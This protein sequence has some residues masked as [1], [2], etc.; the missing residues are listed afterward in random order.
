[1]RKFLVFC[2]LTIAGFDVVSQQAAKNDVLLKLNGEE[3][4]GKV[5]KINENNV[6]FSYAGETLTYMIKKDDIMKITF[7]SGRI[8]IFNKP[9]LPS[10]SKNQPV[11]DNKMTGQPASLE[12]HH[13]KVAILPFS[14]IK[15][16]QTTADAMTEKVQ[17]EGYELLNKHAGVYTILNPRTTNALLLKAGINN[18]NIKGYT[19]DDLCNIL[20]VEYVIDCMVSVDKTTQTVVQSNSGQI[21][22]KNEK[23]KKFNTYTYGTA[24]QNYK[25][26]LTLSIYNDKG[27]TVYSKDRNSFWN[28]EDAYKNTLEYLLKHSPLY[29]K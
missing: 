14:F 17:T 23:D 9:A 16:G 4:A 5:L 1:M 11:S 27:N 29:T 15:D 12:D 8:E 10:E 25:T 21:K 22:E 20:G 3:L 18:D 6:E 26:N 24:T 13:N 19:M 7:S 28:T 2:L